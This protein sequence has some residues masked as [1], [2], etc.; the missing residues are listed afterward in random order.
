MSV[1]DSIP[2]IANKTTATLSMSVGSFQL[3]YGGQDLSSYQGRVAISCKELSKV[4]YF[5]FDASETFGLA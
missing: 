1:T 4:K 3:T 2:E 5:T